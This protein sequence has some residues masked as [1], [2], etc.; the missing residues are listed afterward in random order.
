[1]AKQASKAPAVRQE[2]SMAAK[3]E[4]QDINNQPAPVDNYSNSF[5]RALGKETYCCNSVEY[6]MRYRYG[7]E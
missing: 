6:Q 3:S 2:D 1:M 7:Q 5:M 4:R